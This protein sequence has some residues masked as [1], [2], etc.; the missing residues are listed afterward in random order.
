AALRTEK[1]ERVRQAEVRV[2][3]KSDQAP[4]E[5]LRGLLESAEP[6]TRE[7]AVRAL[8][9]RHHVDPWPWPQ[10]RPRPFP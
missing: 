2:L 6:K 1:H 4:A 5:V 7:M 10:P 8:A 3:A 9:G